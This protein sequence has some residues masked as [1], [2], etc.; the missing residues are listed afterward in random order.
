MSATLMRNSGLAASLV[1]LV[2][3]CGDLPV[4]PP[5]APPP[6]PAAPPFAITPAFPTIQVPRTLQLSVQGGDDT[7]T[8]SWEISDQAVASV[9]VSGL[10]TATF[11]GSA[12]I[13]ARRGGRTAELTLTVTAARVD[14]GPG[15]ASVAVYG[16]TALTATVRDAEGAVLSGVPVTWSSANASIATV[17]PGTGMVAGHATGTTT[18]TATGGGANSGVTLTVTPPA[19]FAFRSVGNVGNYACGLDAKDGFAYCWGDGHAGALGI[20][21]NYAGSTDYPV[22]VSGARRFS[23]ISVGFYA[24]C[25]V[26]AQ[27]GLAYCWGHNGEG[28][29]GDGTTTTRWEPTRVSGGIRFST[30]SATGDVACGI[31]TATGL[32]YCWGQGGLIGDGTSSQRSVPTLVANGNLRFSSISARGKTVCGLEAQTS[33]AYCWG[34][35]EFGQLGDGT[36]SD[37]LVPTLVASDGRRFDSIHGGGDVT[38]GIEAQTGLGYCWGHNDRGQLG[39][40]TTTD[41]LVPAGVGGGSLRFSS[42]DAGAC[43]IEVQSGLG[44]CWGRN[45]LGQVGDGTVTQRLVPTLVGNGSPRFSAISGSGYDVWGIEVETGMLYWWGWMQLVPALIWP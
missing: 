19:G 33:L 39:D 20:G 23:G 15:T 31:E 22:R 8:V 28:Q 7:G 45:N 21:D 16:V 9:S 17:E 6:A 30:V 1:L 26:E 3:A 18:I 37:R 29:I 2:L 25:A 4:V 38:C 11:P 32:G 13:T 10:V 35:N 27:T 40:G 44:Y 12:V 36:T 5:P 14:V 24:N 42:L 41:R 34:S 43:G